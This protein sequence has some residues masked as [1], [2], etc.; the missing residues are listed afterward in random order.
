MKKVLRT[1][2]QVLLLSSAIYLTP[3][4]AA[5]TTPELVNK[6]TGGS[7]ILSRALGGSG[8][9]SEA[10]GGSGITSEALGG[11][12]T[13]HSENDARTRVRGQYV[14]SGPI[15]FA[16]EKNQ[17]VVILGQQ[18]R[19]TQTMF[20]KARDLAMEG[21][22]LE[23]I[24]RRDLSGLTAMS[25]K[26]SAKYYIAGSD[27]VTISGET[28]WYSRD[29]GLIQIGDAIIDITNLLAVQAPD[30]LV[31]SGFSFIGIQPNLGGMIIALQAE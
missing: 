9:T 16:D 29:L 18:I 26:E 22:S 30:G 13:V 27:P 17:T 24:V 3:S 5:T 6:A 11:S 20:R 8:I 21:A 15:D 31:S 23:T 10:L 1:S 2:I 7:G 19:M 14:V 25:M 28:K 12:G 4:L